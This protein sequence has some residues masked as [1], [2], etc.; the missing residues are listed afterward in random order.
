MNLVLLLPL[1]WL[2]GAP[3]CA[4]EPGPMVAAA[5]SLRD[6]LPELVEAFATQGGSRARL[7]FGASGNL[8]RQIAQGAPFELFLSADEAFVLALAREGHSLDEGVVYAEGRLA[9]LLS[10]DSPLRLDGTLK[11]MEQALEDG[12]LRRLAIANPE[13][14]P[15]GRAAREVLQA[16]GLWERLGDRLV[17]GESVSQ[18]AQFV[19]TGAADAGI[20]AYSLALSPRLAQCCNQAPLAAELHNPLPQRG[21]LIKGASEAAR[22]LFAFILG[23]RGRDILQRRGFIVPARD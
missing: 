12:R 1:L 5:A 19:S 15:Y 20:V 17:I 22:R 10:K 21:T 7:S 9:I 23:P 6:A 14:A 2:T 8:R 11:D 4:G 16:L 18:A 13:H 3:V